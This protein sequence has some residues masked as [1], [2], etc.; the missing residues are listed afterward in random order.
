MSQNTDLTHYYTRPQV[1]E[2]IADAT[3]AGPPGS[4]GTNGANGNTVLN[5]SGAPGSGIGV[6][7]DFY[8]DTVA[9]KIYGPKAAGV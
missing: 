4:P 5:G 6:N 2:K 8:L 9:E 7:G 3:L 1:D